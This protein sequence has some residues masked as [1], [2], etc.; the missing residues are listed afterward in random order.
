MT[1]VNRASVGGIQGTSYYVRC[2]RGVTKQLASHRAAGTG[3]CK[4]YRSS[5]TRR[6][7]S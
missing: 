4:R 2:P 7:A 3:A 5:M 1:G 6:A